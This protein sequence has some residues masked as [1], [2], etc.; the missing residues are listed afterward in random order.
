M[1]FL[2]LTV[3]FSKKIPCTQCSFLVILLKYRGGGIY[4]PVINL[5]EPPS[6]T[7]EDIPLWR[8]PFCGREGEGSPAGRPPGAGRLPAGLHPRG[9]AAARALPC[10]ALRCPPPPP[11]AGPRRQFSGAVPGTERVVNGPRPGVRHV[12]GR[13]LVSNDTVNLLSSLLPSRL[14]RSEGDGVRGAGSPFGDTRPGGG[15][16]AQMIG[17]RPQPKAQAFELMGVEANL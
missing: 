14:L 12:C 17:V 4:S 7:S 1:Y 15:A 6:L 9:G 3:F 16:W 5:L 10:P 2:F 8:R 11:R 13:D